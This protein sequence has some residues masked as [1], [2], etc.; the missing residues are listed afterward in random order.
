MHNR[1]AFVQAPRIAKLTIQRTHFTSHVDHLECGK[2]T[3]STKLVYGLKH[4]KLVFTMDFFFFFF[5]VSEY[6]LG[7]QLQSL[8]ET[9]D[10][11]EKP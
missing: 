10:S 2:Y 7:K 11:E 1:L 9:V 4:I 3:T 6:F 5:K 8:L